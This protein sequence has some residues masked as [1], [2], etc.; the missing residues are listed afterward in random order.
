M[1][2]IM[3]AGRI[4]EKLVVGAAAGAIT[5]VAHQSSVGGQ[6]P[7]AAANGRLDQARDA[8]V[9]MDGGGAEVKSGHGR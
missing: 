8:E 7:L 1:D 3:D 6:L 9:V 4:L 2:R 5:R